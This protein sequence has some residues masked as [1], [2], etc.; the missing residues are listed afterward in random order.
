[1][2]Y[3]HYMTDDVPF[4]SIKN[5]DLSQSRQMQDGFQQQSQP[6]ATMSQNGQRRT[7]VT[8]VQK[9]TRPRFCRQPT[10]QGIICKS[11]IQ[12]IFY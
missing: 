10:L 4:M 6:Q 8:L 2:F 5:Q 9:A 12:Y 11:S 1:M 3:L 7:S